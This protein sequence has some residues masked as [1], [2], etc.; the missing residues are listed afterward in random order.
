MDV[1]EG[2]DLL[3]DYAAW[4]DRVTATFEAVSYTLRIRLGDA[5]AAEAIALRVARGLVSRPL[6]F[7]H[8]GLPYSGRIA[9]LAEDGIVDVREGRLVRHGSWPGFRSALVGVPVD[10]QATLVLT[11]VEGRTDAELAERWGCDAEAAGVRRA[12]TLE[13]LQDLVEDHGD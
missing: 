4:L 12:R 11:C 3:P 9:K 7:R 2:P 5:G 6:V 10:H 1:G 8:W 13:F